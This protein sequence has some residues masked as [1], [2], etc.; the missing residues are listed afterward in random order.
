MIETER[1]S[2]FENGRWVHGPFSNGHPSVVRFGVYEC[3][4]IEHAYQA[5]KTRDAEWQLRIITASEPFGPSGAKSLGQRAPLRKDWESVKNLV[6]LFFLRQKFYGHAGLGAILLS[7]DKE[8]LIEG[9]T[10]HDN[11]WGNCYCHRC[12]TKCGRNV[13]GALLGRVR[14]ELGTV[15]G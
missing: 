9:N 5:A 1:F 10:W 12:S 13:L 4:T 8:E 2:F 6:M 7:T 3:P 11:Y 15:I 14:D